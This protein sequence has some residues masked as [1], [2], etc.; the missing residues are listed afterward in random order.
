MREN[1]TISGDKGHDLIVKSNKSLNNLG[2]LDNS[3]TLNMNTI[4]GRII[5][6][7]LN[8]NLLNDLRNNKFTLRGDV[9]LKFDNNSNS[10]GTIDIF[11]YFKIN[12]KYYEEFRTGNRLDNKFLDKPIEI[13]NIIDKW[14]HPFSFLVP[15]YPKK[16]LD[17]IYNNHRSRTT[18]SG[19]DWRVPCG[20]KYASQNCSA[21]PHYIYLNDDFTLEA[22]TWLKNKPNF[23]PYSINK[24]LFDYTWD[25]DS[26][27]PP[28]TDKN[29]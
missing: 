15:N 12:N 28:L 2:L 7:K 29:Y 17:G 21:S 9:G 16:L 3:G 26:N 8:N 14:P 25:L 13:K 1:G 5:K 20:A 19:G 4:N 6:I 10:K 22:Y 27:N 18:P 11:P 24:E 23:K